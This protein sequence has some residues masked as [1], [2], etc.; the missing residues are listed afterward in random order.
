MEGAL[1]AIGG[2]IVGAVA[3]GI[4]D[5]F[6]LWTKNKKER[7]YSAI[8]LVAALDGFYFGCIDISYDVAFWTEASSTK[9][10][11]QFTLP[12]FMVDDLGVNWKSL[13]NDIAYEVLNFSNKIYASNYTI[14]C[15][16]EHLHDPP[17]FPEAFETRQYEYAKLGL[18]AHELASRIRGMAGLPERD[19]SEEFHPTHELQITIERIE[20]RREERM[21][22]SRKHIPS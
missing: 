6:F 7:D 2:V 18:F 1:I 12:V 10:L 21:E 22:R 16:F 20:K 9:D 3:A 5:L 8:R 14:D 11:G 19:N 15:A 17:D 13:P 4:K